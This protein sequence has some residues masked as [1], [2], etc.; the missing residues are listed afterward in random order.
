MNFRRRRLLQLVATAIAAVAGSGFAWA[1][2]YPT[3]PI[4]MIVGYAV[5]GPTDT[6][7]RIVAERMS[8]SLGQHL[9]V[10]NVTGASGSI[11]VA[12]V[13]RAAPDGCAPDPSRAR[14]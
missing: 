8:V 12:R 9:V 1:Q 6:I 3:R 4:T 10:E 7:A 14:R 5:G 13:A 2:D 11:G